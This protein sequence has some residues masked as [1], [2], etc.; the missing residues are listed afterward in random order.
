MEAVLLTISHCEHDS[1]GSSNRGYYYVW[2]EYSV[3]NYEIKLESNIAYVDV[4]GKPIQEINH[5]FDFRGKIV[6][7]LF[8]E[9]KR[10]FTYHIYLKCSQTGMS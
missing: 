1:V 2:V 10:T 7:L 9:V 6:M 4:V 5:K 3:K 8:D